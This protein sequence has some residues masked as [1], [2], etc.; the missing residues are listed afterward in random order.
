MSPA[1]YLHLRRQLESIKAALLALLAGNCCCIIYIQKPSQDS[2]VDD[3]LEDDFSF[4][5]ISQEQS[6]HIRYCV[7]GRW[8]KLTEN[9]AG[10]WVVMPCDRHG[11]TVERAGRP[12]EMTEALHP[13]LSS[14]DVA[15][16][17]LMTTLRWSPPEIL[18]DPMFL[19]QYAGN[20]LH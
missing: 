13:D 14:R 11:L 5:D 16:F 3:G 2:T 17:F 4:T 8:F 9:P 15:V 18:N 6:F 20:S 19:R 12:E 10:Q 1:S 7:F